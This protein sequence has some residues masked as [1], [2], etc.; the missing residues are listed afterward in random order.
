MKFRGVIL[1]A[2]LIITSLLGNT[3]WAAFAEAPACEA[4]GQLIAVNNLQVIQWKKNTPNK[5]E[6]RA[7]VFGKITGFYTDKNGHD[8]FQIQI[9]P[10]PKDTIE[11]IYNQHFGELPDD[12][13]EGMMVQA[14]GDYI[15]AIAKSGPYPP[16]PDGAIIHWL[17]YSPRNSH[18]HGFLVIEGKVFG[19]KNIRGSGADQSRPEKKKKVRFH[20]KEDRKAD[21]SQ[22]GYR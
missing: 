20:K 12:L 6:A 22:R 17:H 7:N 19:Y 3:S 16:S 13:F 21:R 11:V 2:F 14:C 1:S 10:D 9:G 5:Y 15:T 18:D 8:H 4:K